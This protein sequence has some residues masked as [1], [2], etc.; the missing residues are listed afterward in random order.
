M[1]LDS[2]AALNGWIN[3]YSL[4]IQTAAALLGVSRRT[5]QRWRAEKTT[6]RGVALQI[7]LWNEGT[8][9]CCSLSRTTLKW[10]YGDNY[11]LD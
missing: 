11:V 3:Q 2:Y 9:L 10:A 7:D 1:Q 5:V 6:L 4:S 8:P